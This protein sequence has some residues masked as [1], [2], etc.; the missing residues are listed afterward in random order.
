VTG[1]TACPRSWLCACL[2]AL[3]TSIG[4]APA[5]GHGYLIDGDREAV[6]ENPLLRQESPPGRWSLLRTGTSSGDSSLARV[7]HRITRA[8]FGTG[9]R[10]AHATSVALHALDVAL[11]FAVLACFLRWQAA[12]LGAAAFAFHP[13]TLP[14]VAWVA[15]RGVLFSF[16]LVLGGALLVARERGRPRVRRARIVAGALLS[17]VG[18]LPLLSGGREVLASLPRLVVGLVAPFRL[19][20]W[21]EPDDRS[22]YALSGIALALVALAL[23]RLTARAP[24]LA[25]PIALAACLAVAGFLVETERR[26]PAW[27]DQATLAQAAL[28]RD[29]EDARA[30]SALA[31]DRLERGKLT[32]AADHAR[33]ALA[34]EPGAGAPHLVLATIALR[35]PTSPE[36]R[37]ELQEALQDVDAALAAAPDDP[38]AN[39]L[40]GEVLF[41]VGDRSSLERAADCLE[42]AVRGAPL[43]LRPRT[44]LALVRIQLGDSAAARAAAQGA[45]ELDPENREAWLALAR[46]ARREGDAAGSV[47][48]YERA[49]ASEPAYAE[50][51]IELGMHWLGAGELARAHELLERAFLLHPLY[52]DASFE[53]ARCLDA[54]GDA[55]GAASMYRRAL[56]AD[57]RNERARSRLEE[58]APGEEEL[59]GGR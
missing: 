21:P 23:G 58:L 54:E 56:E 47:A 18:L 49:L 50:A 35:R 26:L 19:S 11:L 59:E 8:L 51:L 39:A 46:A 29:P 27:H 44:R 6:V 43:V 36:A 32:E 34:S 41:R 12:V 17:S 30:L 5:F 37:R 38:A 13:L 4:F 57:P 25:R 31:R 3:A 48:A 7:S 16:A 53:L 14:G 10:P 9:P 2:L 22:L 40:C 45:L 24:R 42:R 1:W 28:A 15:S 20:P 55:A 52:P 33:A